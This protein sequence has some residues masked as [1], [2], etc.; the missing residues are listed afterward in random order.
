MTVWTVENCSHKTTE[1][2]EAGLSQ[3]PKSIKLGSIETV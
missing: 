2:F 1:D 3:K